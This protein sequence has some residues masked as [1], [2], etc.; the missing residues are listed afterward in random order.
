ML[1]C[2]F[3]TLSTVIIAG[4]A[5]LGIAVTLTTFLAISGTSALTYAVVREQTRLWSTLEDYQN[6]PVVCYYA[7]RLVMSR[8]CW[9]WQVLSLW[10]STCLGDDC[11][12]LQW[13]LLA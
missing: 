8:R 3:S 1:Q 13:L 12:G 11:W 9:C 10:A 6:L 7:R 4:S 2:R 5:V